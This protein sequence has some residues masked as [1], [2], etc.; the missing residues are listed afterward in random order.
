MTESTVVTEPGNGTLEIFTLPTD[1]EF[2]LILITD[3]FEN[4]WQD[5]RFRFKKPFGVSRSNPG[6]Y[7]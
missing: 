1:T 6:F 2:L 4:Y 7:R 5:F 3:I